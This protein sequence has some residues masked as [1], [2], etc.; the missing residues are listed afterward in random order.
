MIKFDIDKDRSIESNF[1]D[2]F[3]GSY[4]ALNPF[5]KKVF[6]DDFDV[7]SCLKDS[8]NL[9]QNSADALE[10]LNFQMCKLGKLSG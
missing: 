10:R 9:I 2:I 3:S 4:I 7:R 8:F 6:H 5:Y 1:M